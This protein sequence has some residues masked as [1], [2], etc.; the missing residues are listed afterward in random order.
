MIWKVFFFYFFSAFLVPNIVCEPKRPHSLSRKLLRIIL[1]NCLG[2]LHL[3]MAGICGELFL[4]AVS[5]ET[6]N[7]NSSKRGNRP[8]FAHIQGSTVR[9]TACMDSHCIRRY[10]LPQHFASQRVFS[11]KT[12]LSCLHALDTSNISSNSFLDDR[13]NLT[14]PKLE[15]NKPFLQSYPKRVSCS[16]KTWVDDLV[17]GHCF[18]S[19]SRLTCS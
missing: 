9:F 6:K 5:H 18:L 14:C 3:K 19:W 17:F 7:E 1:S 11:W 4:V 10:H 2:I 12:F 8:H 15:E 13:T 16:G